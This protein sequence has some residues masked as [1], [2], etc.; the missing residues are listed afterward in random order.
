[1]GTR[2]DFGALGRQFPRPGSG[3]WDVRGNEMRWLGKG[4]NQGARGWERM[5]EAHV[6]RFERHGMRKLEI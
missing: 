4:A 3:K 6:I 2:L 5:G 1:V